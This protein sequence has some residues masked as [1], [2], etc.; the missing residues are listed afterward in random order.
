[1]NRPIANQAGGTA[2]VITPMAAYRLIRVGRIGDFL[3]SA[4]QRDGSAL[5]P[6]IADALAVLEEA[7]EM[8]RPSL[9]P[10]V[11]LVPL[12]IPQSALSGKL[13]T[14]K[15]AAER[16]GVS[17]RWVRRLVEQGH[18]SRHG[19]GRRLLV[20]EDELLALKSADRKELL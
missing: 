18:L 15:Q 4:A 17:D 5:D 8:Y 9:V 6:V 12:G 16:A 2:T 3:R 20:D 1:M 19:S 10:L 14:T 7:A 11:P 13:L